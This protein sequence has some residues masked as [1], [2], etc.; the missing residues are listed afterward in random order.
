MALLVPMKYCAY[1]AILH[2]V[3]DYFSTMLRLP[4]MYT[5]KGG[6]QR[7]YKNNFHFRE[8]LGL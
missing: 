6:G 3:I 2:N 7:M 1:F 4:N 8:M 5:Y